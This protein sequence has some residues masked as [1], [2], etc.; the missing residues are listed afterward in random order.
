[1]QKSSELKLFQLTEYLYCYCVLLL[2]TQYGLLL[3]PTAHSVVALFQKLYSN[4]SA[5]P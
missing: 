3:R 2:Y 5:D 1:M 4:R